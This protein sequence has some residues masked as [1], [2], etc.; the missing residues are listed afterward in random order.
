MT[1]YIVFAHGS[2]VASAN[3]AVRDV[4]GKLAQRLPGNR[5]ETAFLEFAE[6]TLY[7]A[8][9]ALANNGVSRAV[10]VPYFLTLGMHLQRDLPKL[11]EQVRA[12]FPN[13]QVEVTAPL[14]GHPALVDALENRALTA[15]N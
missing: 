9:E 14:D 10:V 6:P 5:I 2:N 4:A 11:V 15:L 3:D 1:G 12:D 13:L 8:A 7:Q